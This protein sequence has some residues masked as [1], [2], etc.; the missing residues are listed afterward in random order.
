M[1]ML[2]GQGMED[3]DAS[4]YDGRLQLRDGVVFQPR[5]VGEKARRAADRCGQTSIGVNLYAEALEFSDH[6]C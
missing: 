5:C 6:G 1:G 2:P 4:G 3:F